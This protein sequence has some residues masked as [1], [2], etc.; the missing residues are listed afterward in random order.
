MTRNS[1]GVISVYVDGV[2]VAS[3]NNG[4]NLSNWNSS[5]AFALANELSG[6]RP[7]LGTYHLAAVYNKALT[8]AEV[9]QNYNAGA[10]GGSSGPINQPPTANAGAD[11]TVTDADNNGSEVVTLNGSGST[12]SDG[13]IVSY[14]WIEGSSEIATDATSTVDLGV[15]IHNITLTVTDDDGATAFDTVVITV[16][17]GATNQPPVANAGSDQTVTDVDSSGS[18]AVTLNGSASTDSDGTIVSYSWTEG[19]SQIATGAT[20][21]VDLSVGIHNITLIVTDDGGATAF[22]TVVITVN[23]GAVNQPPV[24]NAGP[25]QTIEDGDNSGTQ[26]VTLNGSASSDPEGGLLRY[27]W[28]A[29]GVTIPEGAIVAAEFP[30]GTTEVTLTVVDPE[31]AQSTDTVAITVNAGPGNQSPIANAGADQTVTD[32]D[33]SG[34][35]LVALNGSGSNDPD[36]TIASYSWNEGGSEIA[37]GANPSVNLSVGTHNITLIVTDNEGATAFD[38]LVI[39]VEAVST[40]P[41][42]VTDGLLALY[43][44][45]E[46]GGSTVADTSGAGTP[47]NLTISNTGNVTWNTGALTVNSSTVI[48]S[49]GPATKVINAVMQSNAITLE[50][51]IQTNNLS[52]SGPARVAGISGNPS[53]RNITLG[54]GLWGNQPL[55]VY[56]MRLRTRSTGHNGVPSVSTPAGSATTNLTHVVMTH[57]PDGTSTVYVNGVPLA[58]HN[59]GADMSN[60]DT[61]FPMVLANEPTGDRPWLGTY[62]LVAVY[63]RALTS[64]E[65]QQNFNSGAD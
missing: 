28:S 23:G 25:D 46:N 15:G 55:T 48:Q 26:S 62:H 36:G 52:Q 45:N 8:S 60:W 54:Q 34:S 35:E 12:D 50:A 29:T 61:S 53:N 59:Q 57:A 22:D 2:L 16:A 47:M 63:S 27:I 39:T 65:V 9:T 18:E 3:R 21:T 41:D 49:S 6:D 30:V 56:D 42:R 5:Y 44:F 32:T 24:A 13:T 51:W 33:S 31:G 58:S 7:W 20:P 11:Q 10:D 4:G 1:S 43:E 14:S 38:T 17:G 37:T 40:G 19:G 64:A